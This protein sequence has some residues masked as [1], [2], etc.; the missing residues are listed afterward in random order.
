MR[1]LRGNK[2]AVEISSIKKLSRV[3]L[4]TLKSKL[5]DGG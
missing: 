5:A 1:E 3:G 4:S 2:N